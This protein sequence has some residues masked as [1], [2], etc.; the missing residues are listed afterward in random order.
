MARN[1]PIE[2]VGLPLRPRHAAAGA[3]RLRH[4]E[5][6]RA[7]QRRFAGKF[8]QVTAPVMAKGVEDTAFYIYNRLLSLNEVGGEPGRF[9]ISARGAPPTLTANARQ[10]GPAPCRRPVTHDTKRSE[11]VRARLNVLS[12]IPEDGGSRAW[13]AGEN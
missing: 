6:D 9:G 11:D 3:A 2:P 10:S 12:E 8:Q 5:E 7:E 4:G 13:P 1:P